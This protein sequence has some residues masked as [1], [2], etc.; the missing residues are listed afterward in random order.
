MVVLAALVAMA[1]LYTFPWV[2]RAFHG[3]R[4]PLVIPV[5]SGLVLG[6]LGAIGGGITLF[7]GGEQMGELLTNRADYDAGQLALI[8][9]VKVVALVVAASASYRGGR[10]FSATFIGVALGLLAATLMPA[11]PLTLAVLG[12]VLVWRVVSRARELRI[13]PET[14]AVVASKL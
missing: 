14:P 3:L 5:V 10:I 9:G 11:I 13:V 2:H 6:Q 1:A 12:V 4:H 8:A 7:K